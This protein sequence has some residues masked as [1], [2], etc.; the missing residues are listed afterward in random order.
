MPDPLTILGGAAASV[1]LVDVAAKL[2]HEIYAFF[3][4]VQGAGVDAQ[5][6]LASQL[7]L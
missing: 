2:S 5:R 6:Q 7:Y 3:R 1:Q 4:S